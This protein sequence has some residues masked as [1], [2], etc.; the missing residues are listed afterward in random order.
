VKSWGHQIVVLYL[1]V[2]VPKMSINYYIFI[3]CLTIKKR[4]TFANYIVTNNLMDIIGRVERVNNDSWYT[5]NK[6]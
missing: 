5:I 2:M 4:Y 1:Q 3:G 6:T